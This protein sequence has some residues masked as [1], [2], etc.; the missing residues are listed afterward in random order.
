MEIKT[1]HEKSTEELDKTLK[2]L[3]SEKIIN[4]V[5]VGFTIGVFVYSILKG[6]IG[7]GSFMALAVA[8]FFIKNANKSNALTKEIEK[9]LNNRT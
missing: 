5:L 7:F 8:Y 2:S 1:I 9:E 3:K 4:A 6:G